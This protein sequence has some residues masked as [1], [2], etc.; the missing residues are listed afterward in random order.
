MP[1]K[2][3]KNLPPKGKFWEGDYFEGTV[4]TYKSKKPCKWVQAGP[5]M[6]KCTSCPQGLGQYLQ[7]GYEVRAGRIVRKKPIPF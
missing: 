1:T 3:P 4:K 7:M 5:S 6:A 2:I